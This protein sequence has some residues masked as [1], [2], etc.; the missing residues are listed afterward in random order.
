VKLVL[1]ALLVL[2]SAC[3]RPKTSGEA[4]SAS[5]VRIETSGAPYALHLDKGSITFCD[6]RGG[7]K[8]TL[9]NGVES[10]SDVECPKI[11][12]PNTACS[13]IG[14]DVEVRAQLP[15]PNDIVDAGARSF[16]LQGRV[17]DCASEGPLIVIATAAQVIVIQAEKGTVRKISDSGGERV[18]AGAGWVAWTQDR[19]IRVERLPP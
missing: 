9:P 7:R 17:H 13:G 12:E 18:A 8:V 15:E 11:E 19:I 6:M 5:Q 16:P 4:A 14:P 3:S 2:A 1:I 10:R